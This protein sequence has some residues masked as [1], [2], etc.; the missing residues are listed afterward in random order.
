MEES[1]LSEWTGYCL[2]A[3]YLFLIYSAY[4]FYGR[5]VGKIK[6]D[7]SIVPHTVEGKWQFGVQED[8]AAVA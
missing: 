6:L 3:L 5:R 7:S 4:P 8:V 1:S 2:M